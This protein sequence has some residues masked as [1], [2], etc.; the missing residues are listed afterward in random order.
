MRPLSSSDASISLRRNASRSLRTSS[1]GTA[2]IGERV[3]G[4]AL[5]VEA[6][7]AQLVEMRLEHRRLRGAA[8]VEDRR[9]QLLRRGCATG[10]ALHV[11]V[12]QHPLVRDV[13][14]DDAQ[15][16]RR[17]DED[18]AHPVLPDHAALEIAELVR[19]CSMTVGA[20]DGCALRRPRRL[21]EC[22][23]LEKRRELRATGRRRSARSAA[24]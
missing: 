9:E 19:T 5:D 17:V 23:A 20:G 4:E 12:V 1:G 13:L 15:A 18:V 16:A 14:V 7:R 10:K 21:H 22:G 11:A 24:A 6:D 3:A 2:E 8:L